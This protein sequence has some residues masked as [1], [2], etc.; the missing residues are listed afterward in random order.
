ME[1]LPYARG[2]I[3]KKVVKDLRFWFLVAMV[4]ASVA[5]SVAKI[6]DLNWLIFQDEFDFA[7]AAL[8]MFLFFVPVV[9]TTWT[10]GFKRGVFACFIIGL[11]MFLQVIDS[12]QSLDLLPGVIAIVAIGIS[13]SWLVARQER[14][15]RSIRQSAE[16]LRCQAVELESELAER[17]RVEEQLQHSQVLASLGEMTAGI[18]HEVNNPLASI[19]LY[20]ELLM[21]DGVPRQARKDLKVIHDEAKRAA[22]IMTALLTYSRRVKPQMRRLD[23]HSVLK[24]A[25]AMRWYEQRVQ[26]ISISTNLLG[27]PLYVKGNSSQLTQ[28]FINLMLNAEEALGERNGG[29]IIITTQIDGERAKVSIAD[30]G[31]GIPEENLG[32]VFHPF[33]TTKS[34][35]EGTGLG[36]STCYGIVTSHD[37]LIRAENNEMGG[38]TFTVELPLAETRRKGSL[39]W[40]RKRADGAH[41]LAVMKPSCL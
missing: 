21:A 41:N 30:D 11:F 17:K 29:N 37:G 8:L 39:P 5:I 4:T 35:G 6:A 16:K 25:L 26:N 27:G 20:S 33:F 14:G 19:I 32:W 36:L 10:F 18:A 3:M 7:Y 1:A 31:T 15:E 23:L 34:I 40:E 13:A 9:I 24:K 38:A 28:V 2:T 22:R 12:L